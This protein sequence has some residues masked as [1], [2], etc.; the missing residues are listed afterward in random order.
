MSNKVE[1]IE[2]KE[3]IEKYNKYME[4]LK[5]PKT[6]MTDEKLA[7]LKKRVIDSLSLDR[8][9]LLM[10]Q[11]FTGGMLMRFDFVPVRDHRLG[12]ASTDGSRIFF[13]IDFYKNLNDEERVFVLAHECWHC[14]YLHFARRMNRMADLWNIATDCEINYMLKNEMFKTPSEV[15]FPPPSMEGKSAEEIYE[16]YLKEAKKNSKQN[17]NGSPSGGSGSQSGGSSSNKNK[18]KDDNG[19]GS[20]NKKLS[21]QFDKHS[22]QNK[23]GSK[24]DN[25]GGNGNGEKDEGI[26]PTDEWGE[27]GEDPDYNPMIDNDAA[28]KIR[29]A[30]IAE[31]Q[32]VERQQGKLPGCV[33]R[34]LDSLRQP[35]I[36]WQEL[37]SQFVT[38][39]LGDKR[40][41]LPPLRRS[42]W[43]E[44][45]QQSRRGQK[46]NVVCTVDTSGSTMTDLPKFIAE[47]VSL[48]KTFGRYEMTLIQCDAEVQDVQIYDECN[49][50]PLDNSEAIKWKGMGGS[51]LNPAFDEILKRGTEATMH[52][53]FTD[54]YI[55]VPKKNPLGIPTMFILTKDGNENLCDWGTKL[56][57]KEI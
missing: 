39:C 13:D 31:A 54:G 7:D 43:S 18:K 25:S 27:K 47:L 23:D 2:D 34:V 26:L 32:I 8:Q 20:G 5:N 45:Y 10:R 4:A 12:T 3:L 40:Q 53:I 55:Y 46:I 38:S 28:E 17:K 15:C 57:F 16:Y 11:P 36:P 30:V 29:E 21:G 49:E 41:W 50:F 56:K 48:L 1:K 35:E 19:S 42:V 6:T 9:K 51:N 14:V 33:Q 24:D 22:S 37:L 52:L 44:I